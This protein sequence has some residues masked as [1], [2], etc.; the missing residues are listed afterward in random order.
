[1]LR[2]SDS[3][4]PNQ[5]FGFYITDEDEKVYRDAK[6]VLDLLP[7]HRKDEAIYWKLKERR[8]YDKLKEALLLV[9]TINKYSDINSLLS[10]EIGCTRWDRV[11]RVTFP[12]GVHVWDSRYCVATF[13]RCL[14]MV[15][16]RTLLNISREMFTCFLLGEHELVGYRVIEGRLDYDPDCVI[17][18]RFGHVTWDTSKK[19]FYY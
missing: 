17:G 8:V 5:Q 13:G 1:M 12:N 18:S 2:C 3:S 6:T 4:S 10:L 11:V 15:C 16:L 9:K 7:H 19:H 14:N